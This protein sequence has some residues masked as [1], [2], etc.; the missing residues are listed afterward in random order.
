[1][2]VITDNEGNALNGTFAYE[3]DVEAYVNFLEVGKNK[4]LKK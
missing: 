4:Y 1:L 3:E 2:Y